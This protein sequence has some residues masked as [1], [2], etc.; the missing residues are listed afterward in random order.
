MKQKLTDIIEQVDTNTDP[1]QVIVN[2]VVA[3]HCQQLDEYMEAVD[4]VL[5]ERGQPSTA[6]LEEMVLNL[7]SLLY[8]AGTG[9][10]NTTIRASMAKM[11]VEEKYNKVYNDTVGTIGD[12]KATAQLESQNESL[13]KLCYSNAV[14]L[15]QHKIDR[16]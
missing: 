13:V 14:S 9:L 12:K 2:E 10:E 4:S 11:V 15:Y 1:L 6:E 16:F 3:K 5:R 8:W 7:N